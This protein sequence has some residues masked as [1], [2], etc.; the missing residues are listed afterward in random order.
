MFTSVTLYEFFSTQENIAKT[1]DSYISKEFLNWISYRHYPVLSWTRKD[2]KL[3][4]NFNA[5]SYGKWWIPINLIVET[6]VT[7]ESFKL[8]LT[9]QNPHFHVNI[10]VLNMLDWVMV[11][12]QQAGKYLLK[13]LS[14]IRTLLHYGFLNY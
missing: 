13:N 4:Q 6:S 12:I 9:Q 11:D 10:H 14:L 1:Y 2:G 8:Y 7:S 5:S 3:T